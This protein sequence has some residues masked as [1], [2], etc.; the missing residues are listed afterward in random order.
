[1]VRSPT[2]IERQ[3]TLKLAWKNP[4]AVLQ[5]LR[6]R[7]IV[8][9]SGSPLEIILVDVDTGL[10]VALRQALRLELVLLNVELSH[11]EFQKNII[12]KKREGMGPLLMGDVSLTMRDGRA[13]VGELVVGGLGHADN[14]SW[15]FFRMLRIGARVVPGTFDGARVHEAITDPLKPVM[16][17]RCSVSTS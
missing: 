5:L 12:V 9:I 1:L 6:G 7:K 15:E 14:P 2:N 13:V 10:P 17:A 3:P 11:E 8:D 16:V 4:L